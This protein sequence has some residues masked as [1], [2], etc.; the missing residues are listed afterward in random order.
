MISYSKLLM[1]EY[2]ILNQQE[3]YK[4]ISYKHLLEWIRALKLLGLILTPSILYLFKVSM[5]N[6]I[7]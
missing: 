1:Y 6:K 7:I 4:L 3:I 2:Y 5:S